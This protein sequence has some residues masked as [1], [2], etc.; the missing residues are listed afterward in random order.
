MGRGY[1]WANLCPRVTNN[2]Q[3]CKHFFLAWQANTG[4]LLAYGSLATR[5]ALIPGKHLAVEQASYYKRARP[6]SHSLGFKTKTAFASS[7]MS[8][9]KIFRSLLTKLIN[10]GGEGNRIMG[11]YEG[12]IR[13]SLEVLLLIFVQHHKCQNADISPI[14]CWDPFIREEW[15]I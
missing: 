15:H 11:T 2:V 13:R 10:V 14:G 1:P 3:I 7:W 12:L 4:W 6:G 8:F 5:E 9:N